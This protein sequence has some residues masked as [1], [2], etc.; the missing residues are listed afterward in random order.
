VVAQPG[1]GGGL[2]EDLHH[3][4]VE[5]AG[6]LPVPAEGVFPGDPAL[7]V[8]D[9]AERQIGLAEQPVVGDHAVPGGE[10]VRHDSE[11]VA[12]RVQQV[13]PI[14]GAERTGPGQA[15]DRGPD[16]DRA[17][18]DDELVVAEQFLAALGGGDQ[19][20]A[21]GH[22]DAA[23]GGIQPQPHPGRFQVADGAVGQVAPVSD[24]AGD[25]AGDTADGKFG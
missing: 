20:L 1:P 7:L 22:V 9:G 21:A 17:G 23:G 2:V 18:A 15:A 12:H 6:K 14:V 5:A 13:H 8:G 10:H 4:G 19:E 24:L 3:L 16:R 11:G 25:V